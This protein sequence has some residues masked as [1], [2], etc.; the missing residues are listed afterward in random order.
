M[1]IFINVFIVIHL[2]LLVAWL[3]PVNTTLLSIRDVFQNYIIFLG[4]DQNYSMFAPEVRK[5]NRHLIALIT[6][7]DLSTLVWTY[8]RQERL[9]FVQAIQKERYRKFSN[10][11]IVEPSFRMYLPDFARYVAKNYASIYACTETKP[12]Q[13]SFYLSETDIP[14]PGQK[15]TPAS[16][17]K[18]GNS[19]KNEEFSRLTNIFTYQLDANDAIYTYQNGAE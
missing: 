10:D 7:Q 6:F 15:L 13:I 1:R 18:E 19:T 9:G 8:P 17:N 12:S 5:T 2:M 16:V 11:N 14:L 4:L 3:F